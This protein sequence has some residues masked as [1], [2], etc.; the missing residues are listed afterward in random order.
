MIDNDGFN[1]DLVNP[2]LVF[3]AIATTLAGLMGSIIVLFMG[4]AR[5]SNSNVF[6]RVALQDIQ[7]SDDGFTS[8]TYANDLLKKTGKSYS[9]LRPSGKVM[10]DGEMYDAYT[11]GEYIEKDTPIVVISTEGTSLKVKSTE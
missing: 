5:L 3:R 10:I 7:D 9:I 4:G 8:T 11:R 2:D 6:K 1:F